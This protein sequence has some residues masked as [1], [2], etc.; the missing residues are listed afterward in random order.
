M[1]SVTYLSLV[2]HPGAGGEGGT[3]CKPLLIPQILFPDET[4]SLLGLPGTH[5]QPHQG[6]GY[7]H[8]SHQTSIPAPICSEPMGRPTL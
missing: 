6:I 2:M 3:G 5:P 1:A 8:Q 7:L 4:R